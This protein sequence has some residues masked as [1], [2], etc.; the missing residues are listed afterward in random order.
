[1]ASTTTSLN[2][3][4]RPKSKVQP[5][6]SAKR[7]SNSNSKETKKVTTKSA[8]TSGIFSK[9]SESMKTSS[10]SFRETY[11]S[12]LDQ[13]RKLGLQLLEYAEEN[14]KHGFDTWRAVI[15]SE[16][17]NDAVKIQTE[18]VREGVQRNM[19][20]AR[21]TAELVNEIGRDTFRPVGEFVSKVTNNQASA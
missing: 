14:T 1:M 16:N 15:N 9:L 3:S 7:P 6:T 5:T 11:G 2:G 10:E 13:Q 8:A 19:T 18:A 20:Q 17:I 12:L 21:E 4:T